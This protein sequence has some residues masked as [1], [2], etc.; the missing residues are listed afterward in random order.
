[1]RSRFHVAPLLLAAGLLLC[2]CAERYGAPIADLPAS[3]GWQPLPIGAWVLNDGL[4]AR[5][6]AFCPR[7]ACARQGF[8][9][10]VAFE[11]AEA[12]RMEQALS[13]KP[14]ELAR[15]FARLDREKA[16]ARA[17][18]LRRAGKKPPK[19]KPEGSVTDYARFDSEDARGILVTIRAKDAPVRQG[20]AAI[21]YGRMGGRLVVALAVSDDAE[22][23]KRDAE[24][25]W[26]SR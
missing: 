14:A 19:P 22:A 20:V 24:A 15:S 13:E 6:M 2:A 10:V 16:A 21:L 7:D 25:A 3:A 26:R 5:S 11:G 8:A 23:A 1:M 9:A 12:R 4:E 17:A 18:E